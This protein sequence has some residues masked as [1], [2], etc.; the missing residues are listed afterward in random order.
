MSPVHVS[1]KNESNSEIN[2]NT[3]DGNNVCTTTFASE[4]LL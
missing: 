3:A 1:S 2:A 4:K